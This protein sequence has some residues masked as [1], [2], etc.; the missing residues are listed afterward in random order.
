MG[1]LIFDRYAEIIPDHSAWADQ[2]QAPLPTAFWVN[3]LKADSANVLIELKKL[4]FAPEA[5]AWHAHGFRGVFDR[6]LGNTW[7]YLAGL[8]HIQEEVSM[9]PGV[10]L[11]AE[12][13]ERVL[14]LCAAPGNKTAQLAV[15]MANQGTLIANDRDFVRMRAFSQIQKRLGLVNVTSTI[16]DATSYPALTGYFDKIMAD[17]P[18]SCEGTFRKGKK[19]NRQADPHL[20]KQMAKTQTAILKKAIQCCRADGTVIYSTCT[21]APEE[22]EAV[23][24]RVLTELNGQAELEPI[25]IDGFITSEGITRWQD[26]HY[27]SRLKHAVRV[28]PHQNNTGGFFIAKIK[29]KRQKSV[30]ISSRILPENNPRPEVETLK[31]RFG[32]A[33]ESLASYNFALSNSK[34]FFAVNSDN[35]VPKNIKVDA[36]GLFFLKNKIKFP[37]LSTAAAMLLSHYV[38][39]NYVE[40]SPEQLTAYFSASSFVITGEQAQSLESVG[41]VIIRYQ[42]YGIGLG[43]YYPEND[44]KPPRVQSLFP[45]YLGTYQ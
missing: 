3:T 6:Q 39:K 14:D 22:N 34:G 19:F 45:R 38:T 40:L 37:K 18:C 16:Y 31:T 21:F 29:V 33:E 4:G 17:V 30:E 32:L 15:S 41:Y 20:S 7:L 23:V 8:I 1:Q 24:D 27:D 11:K 12:P 13:H 43:V 36:T 28:W 42:G 9:L 25:N 35:Q 5:I 10:L 26:Q 2:F 44:E